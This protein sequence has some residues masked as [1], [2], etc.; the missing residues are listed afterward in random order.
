MRAYDA[1]EASADSLDRLTTLAS[2]PARS[3]RVRARCRAQLERSRRR[4]ARATGISGFASRVLVP[5]VVGAICLL[6]VAVLVATTLL[7]ERIFR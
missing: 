3:E 4:A 6:Y 5:T 1:H 7:F 2:D